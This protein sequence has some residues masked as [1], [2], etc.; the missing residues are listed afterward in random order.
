MAGRSLV[1]IAVYYAVIIA[2]AA[3]YVIFSFNEKWG[4]DPATFFSSD[5][6]SRI[7]IRRSDSIL[8]PACGYLC[9]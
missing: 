5:S 1:F 9:C 8:S 6:F 3:R 4:D 2:W 7:L